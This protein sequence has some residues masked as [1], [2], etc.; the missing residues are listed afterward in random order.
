MDSRPSPGAAKLALHDD[1]PYET[2][3]HVQRST[4]KSLLEARDWV[5]ANYEGGPTTLLMMPEAVKILREG[6]PAQAIE[7]VCAETTLRPDEAKEVLG[8]LRSGKGL[9]AM[10]AMKRLVESSKVSQLPGEGLSRSADKSLAP[11]EVA[12]G[13]GALKW[14][15]LAAVALGLGFLLLKG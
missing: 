6:D 4:G 10:R 9:A 7:L 2:I 15:V 8:E 12:R 1:D 5:D 11:G 3:R 13:G 14:I